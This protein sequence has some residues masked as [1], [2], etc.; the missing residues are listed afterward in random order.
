MNCARLIG[1][2]LILTFSS[3]P[4]MAG[5]ETKPPTRTISVTGTATVKVVPDEV[6]LSIGV[7]STNL[8]LETA[9]NEV[10]A[11]IKKVMAVVKEMQIEAKDVQTD[12]LSMRPKYQQFCGAQ[13]DRPDKP[14][15]FV[16]YC[17]SNDVC[18]ILRDTS[19]CEQLITALLAAGVNTIDDV[20]FETSK[21]RQ[22]RD[23][24]RLM[25]VQVAKEKAALIAGEFGM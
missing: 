6:T 21:L 19:R 25:A 14:P 11:A 10:D 7:T 9:K 23:K 24:A 20:D 12:R 1:T 16:G 17:V 8:S 5:D 4:C 3:L 2:A 13:S 22:H 18:I 15:V